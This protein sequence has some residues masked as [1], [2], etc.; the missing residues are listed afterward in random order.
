[1]ISLSGESAKLGP[2]VALWNVF[3]GDTLQL[4]TSPLRSTP[5]HVLK[6]GT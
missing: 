6:N 3:E 2:P 4:S 5:I 1:M